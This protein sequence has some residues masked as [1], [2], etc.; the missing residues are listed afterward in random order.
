MSTTAVC[1]LTLAT[2]RVEILD[3]RDRRAS[4][5]RSP[6][7]PTCSLRSVRRGVIRDRVFQLDP[8]GDRGAYARPAH[9]GDLTPLGGGY[10]HACRG[11][12]GGQA[13]GLRGDAQ[14][15]PDGLGVA[16]DSDPLLWQRVSAVEEGVSDRRGGVG[17]SQPRSETIYR[18]ALA[19]PASFGEA[20]NS[21]ACTHDPTAPN[22]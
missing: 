19:T 3:V 8:H 16:D 13:G 2:A 18:R 11:A 22:P 5:P 6:P 17:S 10:T 4:C 12:Q 15:H 1:D 21:R 14:G 20:R 7:P 9:H